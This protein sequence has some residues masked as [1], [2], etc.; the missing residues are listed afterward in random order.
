MKSDGSVL[1]P[2]QWSLRPA[3]RQIEIGDFPVNVAVHPSGKYAA[4]LHSGYGQHE[5]VV[6]AIPSGE[7]TARENLKESFYGLEFS[8]SGKSLVS[9]GAGEEV[10]HVFNFE[11]GKLSNHRTLP[12]R[13]AN[14]RG[15]PAGLALDHAAK[16][17]YV[18]N[19]WGESVT[20]LLI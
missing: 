7:I 10:I 17:V 3:G 12:L 18:Q 16:K 6:I 2:N 4:V 15:V 13:D 1:L 19:V 8:S 11:D 9:S 14:Q 20:V 5:I